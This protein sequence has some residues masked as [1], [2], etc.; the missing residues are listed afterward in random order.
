M[1]K[2]FRILNAVERRKMTM[3]VFDSEQIL[4][5]VPQVN[6][7]FRKFGVFSSKHGEAEQ[8]KPNKTEQVFK[9]PQ[10]S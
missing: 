3:Q 9:N 1:F 2:A 5:D 7:N 6:N 8:L 4:N 10:I